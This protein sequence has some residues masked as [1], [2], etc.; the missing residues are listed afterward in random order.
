[1]DSEGYD[2]YWMMTKELWPGISQRPA[3]PAQCVL[4]IT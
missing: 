2:G 1:M 3:P 4:I